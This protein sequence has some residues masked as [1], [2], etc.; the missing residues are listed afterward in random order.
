MQVLTGESVVQGG[1]Q[2]FPVR[3]KDTRDRRGYHNPLNCWEFKDRPQDVGGALN[4]GIQ[5]IIPWVC[6][7]EQDEHAWN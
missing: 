2:V 7:L 1:N 3:R 6:C 5:D 4:G